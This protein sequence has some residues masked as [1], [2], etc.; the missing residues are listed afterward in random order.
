VDERADYAV[1]CVPA[2]ALDQLAITPDLPHRQRQAVRGVNYASS[3]K[4]LVHVSER[5]WE[6]RDGVFGGGSFTDLPIQQSWYP[7]DNAELV[8]GAQV[9]AWMARD[10]DLSHAPAVLTGAYLWEGNARR[11]TTLPEEDR[12]RLVLDSLDRLHPGLSQTVDDIVHWNWD[13]QV[14]VGGGAFAYPAPG[15]HTRYLEVLGNPHPAEHPR[16]FFAGEHLSVAHAWIQGALQSALTAVTDVL[17]A[18]AVAPVG[19]V[20]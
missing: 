2:P 10:P 17:C 3:S 9:P 6:H 16:V 20:R 4:T 19:A 7:N 18:A 8:P 5:L 15:Q 14:G 13:S 1:V 12:T 11:F